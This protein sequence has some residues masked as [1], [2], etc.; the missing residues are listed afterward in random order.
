MDWDA[1][2]QETDHQYSQLLTNSKHTCAVYHYLS[3]PLLPARLPCVLFNACISG[4]VCRLTSIIEQYTA[5][6]VVLSKAAAELEATIGDSV[7]SC[8]LR[9][10][11]ML[12]VKLVGLP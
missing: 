10:D 1:R 12:K 9:A 2:Q 6:P 7:A 3:I 11:L 4:C 5:W 8:A